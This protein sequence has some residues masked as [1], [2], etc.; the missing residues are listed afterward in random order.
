MRTVSEIVVEKLLPPACYSPLPLARVRFIVQHYFSCR[1]ASPDYPYSA[2]LCWQLFHDLNFEPLHRRFHIYEGPRQHASAH[3]LIPRD[4]RAWLLVPM[5]LCA[6]H[7][8]ASYFD[9]ASD[10][11]HCSIGIESIGWHNE[12]FTDA[13]YRTNAAICAA[14]LA[15]HG[16]TA[17]AIVA[18]SQVAIPEG[19]KRDPGPLFDWDLLER[20]V[21]QAREPTP[22][23]RNG[24]NP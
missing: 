5:N 24:T 21:E 23:K 2:E 14:L 10:L 4:G 1:Y 7:A 9:G 13:Q 6:Y 19:R 22:E 20:Y 18:H 12:P 16:L 11:N 15:E 8:G 3:I 17:Q